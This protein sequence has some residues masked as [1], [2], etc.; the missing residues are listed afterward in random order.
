HTKLLLRVG[1]SPTYDKKTKYQKNINEYL[2]LP[3]YYK[4]LVMAE[5]TNGEYTGSFKYNKKTFEEAKQEALEDCQKNVYKMRL[6]SHC[7]I[8]Y[9]NELYL[10][11]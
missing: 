6:N 7:K 1:E 8:I 5:D 11:N 3:F 2:D 9:E 10:G 4:A